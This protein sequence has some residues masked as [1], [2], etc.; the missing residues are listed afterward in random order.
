M[1]TKSAPL[2]VPAA[3]LAAGAW[4]AFQLPFLPLPLLVL[5]AALGRAWGR[6]AGPPPAALAAGMLAAAM[7][8]GLPARAERRIDP[9]RPAEVTARVSGHWL[10][11]DEGWSA[12]ARV[13]SLSQR[14]LQGNR[15]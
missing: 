3:A 4:L 8:H 1:N 5:L 2:L 14:Q 7:T 6:R 10:P 13:V 15:I 9:G 11:D 12:P